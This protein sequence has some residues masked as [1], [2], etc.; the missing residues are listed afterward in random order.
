MRPRS[1]WI[2][3]VLLGSGLGG[4]W[5][6][7]P[8]PLPP[9]PSSS[10]SVLAPPGA[11][12]APPA[13]P[14]DGQTVVDRV[15]A[16]VNGDVITMS[17][18]QEAIAIYLRETRE[19]PPATAAADIELQRR[20]LKRL[21]DVRLQVQEA[22]RERI[23]VGDDEVQAVVDDIGRRSEAD[24]AQLEKLQADH[25]GWERLRRD[26]RDQLLA[27]KIRGR[28]LS[29]RVHVTE[30]E[31]DAYVAANRHKLEADLKYHAR[32]LTVLAQPPDQPPAWERARA[33]IEGIRAR[34]L[35]GE[36]FAAL[37][38]THS[39]DGSAA[40]G[41]DLGW[42]ARG[43]LQPVFE[44]AVLKLDKGGV[45]APIRSTD[46]YHLFRLEDREESLPEA[47]AQ[48]RQQARDLL[49]QRKIQERLEEWLDGLRRR[50]LISERL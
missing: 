42:L 48:F 14:P 22:R 29:R 4:C 6:G 39:Q 20:V 25:R 44:T 19:T 34:I 1:V 38:R 40:A 9:V 23:Q 16:E 24:R 27:Q 8:P 15:V 50:A 11:P 41:G 7:P 3:A 43:E 2:G 12:A 45:T 35:G 17:E 49:F 26:L 37:A 13:P 5:S 30:A 32:H 18:L 31:V 33:E 21:V 36:D 47:L 28:R 10:G 46:G